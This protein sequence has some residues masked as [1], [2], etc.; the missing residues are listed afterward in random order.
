ML[1]RLS[2]VQPESFEF[3]PQNLAWARAQMTKLSS[4]RS[5]TAAVMRRTMRSRGTTSLPS[6]WPQRFG[7]IWSSM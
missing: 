1:R 6:R 4:E 5:R 3:L 2:P 7:L